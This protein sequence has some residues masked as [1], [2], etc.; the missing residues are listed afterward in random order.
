MEQKTKPNHILQETHLN[1][2]DKHR[3]RVKGWK[4]IF[5]INVSQRKAGVVAIISDEIDF[6][7]KKVKKDTEGHFI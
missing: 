1:S 6:K 4:M 5:Q 7:I 2:E 3:L